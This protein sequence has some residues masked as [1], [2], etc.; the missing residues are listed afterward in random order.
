MKTLANICNKLQKIQLKSVHYQFTTYVHMYMK[1]FSNL[2][3]VSVQIIRYQTRC[4]CKPS[5]SSSSVPSSMK[6]W[7]LGIELSKVMESFIMIYSINYILIRKF[8]TSITVH[9]SSQNLAIRNNRDFLRKCN[10]IPKCPNCTFSF[11]FGRAY[12]IFCLR[13]IHY[14]E[15]NR[16]EHQMKS[17][18]Q[19]ALIS[20]YHQLIYSI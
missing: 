3:A 4:A 8:M 15:K 20:P 7:P 13:R 1:I 9:S 17:T 5:S 12:T 11:N 2:G 16:I 6:C 18:W 19:M 10:I 14:V